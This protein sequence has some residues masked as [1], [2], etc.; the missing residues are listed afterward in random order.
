MHR[1]YRFSELVAIDVE[2]SDDQNSAALRTAIN[3]GRVLPDELALVLE[4]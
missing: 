4:G 2:L 3:H 1:V